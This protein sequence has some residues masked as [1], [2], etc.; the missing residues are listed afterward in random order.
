M[1]R[2]NKH[3]KILLPYINLIKDKKLRELT[4]IT[5]NEAGEDLKQPS[6]TSGMHHPEDELREYGI[7]VHLRK[8]VVVA[9]S[10]LRRRSPKY[11]EE[12]TVDIVLTATLL[13]DTP[14]RTY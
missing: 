14:F 9:L 12:N 1:I 13:H 6:S 7:T 2:P 11:Y 3:T 8:A 10:A 5:L 4:I